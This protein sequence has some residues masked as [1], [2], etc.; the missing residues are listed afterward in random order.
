MIY[1]IIGLGVGIIGTYFV[2]RTQ[3]LDSA[4]SKKDAKEIDTSAIDEDLAVKHQ[5]LQKMREFITTK[6]RV[7]NDDI[8]KLLNV[9]DATATRYL[10]ELEKEGL[11]RQIGKEGKYTYYNKV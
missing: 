10:D 3:L 7:T 9:S 8:Q 2:M 5:N 11:I 4:R 1:F 6:D